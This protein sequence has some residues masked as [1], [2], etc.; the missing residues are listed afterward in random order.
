[1]TLRRYVPL[2]L[3]ALAL[4]CQ[5]EIDERTNA[6][7]VEYAVFNP[8]ES[9][10]P[11]PNDIAIQSFLGNP[12][13]A[14]LPCN[15][16]LTVDPT[17]KT[18]G[19]CAYSR[20]GGFP[21]AAAY[22]S[23]QI[24]FM[25]GTLGGG[26]TVAYAPSPLNWDGTDTSLVFA[27][28][29]ATEAPTV[30][31]VDA[32]VFTDWA[33][34]VLAALA[35]P[36]TP[37]APPA[38][39]LIPATA[40]AY[41]LGTLTISPSAGSWPAGHQVVALVRGYADGILTDAGATY[42]AMPP[43][44]VLREAVIGNLD[45][46]DP[47]NQ[48]LLPGTA[49]EKLAAGTSLE[50]L[51]LGY[52]SLEAMTQLL[53]LAGIDMP[54]GEL[55]SMQTFQVAPDATITVGD[56]TDPAPPPVIGGGGAPVMIDQFTLVSSV[57]TAT[58]TSVVFVLASGHEG[59]HDLFVSDQSDCEITL[60]NSASV[61]ANGAV[62]IPFT[63][64]Q[65]IGNE[66]PVTYYVCVN[67]EEPAASVDVSGGVVVTTANAVTGMT[68]ISEGGDDSAILTVSPPPAPIP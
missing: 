58:L 3:S 39:L 35:V 59:V 45:L 5:P 48:G 41:D 4:A 11:L 33:A 54:F 50:P 37:P 12:D 65:S 57:S 53:P 7:T 19:L 18:S 63:H 6:T 51:R 62:A 23:I 52:E 64:W 42:A 61:T 20:A 29:G 1:M 14:A 17:G 40:F 22:G 13:Y 46:S 49:E 43:L 15:F 16:F 24:Q 26:G 2:A 47:A 32:T 30:A 66:A 60:G 56:G 34:D 9:Q 55:V 31:V 28:L 68:F 27:A 10:I 38:D 44:Y 8:S 21:K 67:T 25:T 36:T